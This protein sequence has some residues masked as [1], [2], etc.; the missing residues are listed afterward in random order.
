MGTLRARER[1]GAGSTRG[2]LRGGGGAAERPGVAAAGVGRSKRGALRGGGGA[3]ERPGGAERCVLHHD[4]AC[5]RALR[6]WERCVAC[7]VAG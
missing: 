1:C 2:A 5:A 4:A 7:C 3:A 6:G